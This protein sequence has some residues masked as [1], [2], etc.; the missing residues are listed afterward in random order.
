MA[1]SSVSANPSLAPTPSTW[2]ERAGRAAP[3]LAEVV[4][5][6]LFWWL[7][8]GAGRIALLAD[9]DTGWHIRAGQ[10][11]LRNHR[12]PTEDLFSYS[13]PHAE[14]FAWEWLSDVLLAGVHRYL[15]LAG[16]TLGGA[17]L[18]A[19]TSAV[20][21]GYLLWHRV[22]ILVGIVV[23]LVAGSASTIHWLARPH[24][25]TYLLFPI[26]LW[27]LDADRRSPGRRVW[28]LAPLAALWT[29]LHGGFLILPA[30]LGCYTLG[31]LVG[32]D[33][34]GARRYALLTL[35]AAALTLINPYTWR[36]HLH[37]ARYLSSD[38][39]RN[40]VMEFQS[41][42]FRGESMLA[43]ELLLVTGLIL[44]PRLWRRGEH[45]TALL[46]VALAHASLG[47]VRHVL[48]YVL[49]A[50]PVVARELT[51]LLSRSENEWLRALARVGSGGGGPRRLRAPLYGLA[52]VALAA[53]LF[54]AGGPAWQV[55]DFPKQKFPLAALAVADKI[56]LGA[57]MFTSDQWADY[58]IYR[59]WPARRVFIDGRS[60]FYGPAL[61]AQY[62][63]ALTAQHGWE[64]IFAQYRFDVA[65]LPAEWPLATVLKAH[66]GWRLDYD[67]G[68]AL[69]LSRVSPT[70]AVSVNPTIPRG[71]KRN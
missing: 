67:D 13:R 39:I 4:F 25:F 48:L 27:L 62:L 3:P 8:A 57:R 51:G 2:A 34:P 26:S 31:A 40:R 41:P 49:A 65:L 45:A 36:L 30:T 14:W 19:A 18:I 70:Y 29:N 46:L 53:V 59:Y 16:V 33:R 66:P 55:P 52:A 50:A 7:L 22:H 9:G 54:R 42:D 24:L 5:L 56:S 11:I 28:L 38:F 47:S 69:L 58:M 20:L 17:V 63:D 71:E 37:I 35:A 43:Y 1:I 6:S 44:I 64:Q 61:G 23:M 21:L 15:G 10:W 60:D 32:R 12:F 68:Q